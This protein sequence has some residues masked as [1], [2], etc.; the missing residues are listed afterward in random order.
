[1][2]LPLSRSG[3]VAA[4]VVGTACAA[5]GWSWAIILIAF[6]VTSTS[7]SRYR[8]AERDALTRGIGEKTAGRDA[9]QVAANGAAFAAIALAYLVNPL[10][11][12]HAAGAGA[13]AASTADTWAT[14]I[15]SLSRKAPRIIVS[16][17]TVPPGTS[18]AVSVAGFAGSIAGAG[19]IALMVIVAGWPQSAACGAIA[20]GL[21]GSIADSLLGATLQEKRWCDACDRGTER[22]IHIC[23]SETR[24]ISGKG[25]VRND[26]V[27][28][29]S[30]LLGALLGLL[31][32]A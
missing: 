13:I 7:L 10:P 25:W 2:N 27:N 16:G 5:A 20:G 11:L 29:V 12:W 31:C 17:Q 14:E 19:F 6:F 18:G 9:L 4:I 28:F 30:S 26:L 22:A 1:M 24:R 23:G 21:G 8:C 32:F 3:A 15:G